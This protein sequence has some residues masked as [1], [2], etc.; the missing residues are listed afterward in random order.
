MSKTSK[1]FYTLLP[2]PIYIGQHI[3]LT[4][5]LKKEEKHILFAAA[6]YISTKMVAMLSPAHYTHALHNSVFILKAFTVETLTAL[7]EHGY[8]YTRKDLTA[9]Q[10]D[11]FVIGLYQV[12]EQVVTLLLFHQTA[13]SL[14]SSAW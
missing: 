10:Q 5:V 12:C 9:Y 7:P 4:S 2:I 11:V 6:L 14:F 8:H 13:T 3:A 1:I